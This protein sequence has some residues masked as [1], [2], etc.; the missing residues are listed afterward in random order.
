MSPVHVLIILRGLTGLGLGLVMP[1]QVLVLVERGVAPGMIGVVFAVVALASV[2]AELPGGALADVHGQRVA[3][4]LGYLLMGAGLVGFAL[5]DDVS[6]FLV[7]AVALGVGKALDSGALETWFVERLQADHRGVHD[8]VRLTHGLAA[9]AMTNGL[10][11]AAGALAGGA[12]AV[13]SA[14]VSVGGVLVGASVPLLLGSTLLNVTALLAVL[15]LRAQGARPG[16]SLVSLTTR[17]ARSVA[18]SVRAVAVDSVLRRLMLRWFMAAAG[19]TVIHLLV[20]IRLEQLL[21]DA[22]RS[23]VWM[24]FVYAALFGL[25]GLA[26]RCA[27]WLRRTVGARRSVVYLGLFSG[28]CLSTLPGWDVTGLLIAVLLCFAATGPGAALLGPLLHSRVCGP[29]RTGVLSVA[30]L[31]RSGGTTEAP[32]VWWRLGL[33]GYD[34]G[35]VGPWGSVGRVLELCGW[36]VVEGAVQALGVVPV[37]PA[38]G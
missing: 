10:G 21:G 9:A 35:L 30:A 38:E 36:D 13:V 31:T 19:M 8:P 33:L 12:L 24:G 22:G 25:Q 26:A 18:D 7:A 20:P 2:A 32:W 17:G 29:H 27:P 4:C 11:I 5:A 37:D 28:L 23:A 1:V 14:P 15:M 34:Q 6:W 3:L 16:G